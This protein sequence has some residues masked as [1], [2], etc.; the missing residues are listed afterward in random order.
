MKPFNQE[1]L[2]DIR[3]DLSGEL[4]TDMIMECASE[5]YDNL[6]ES[7]LIDRWHQIIGKI[8]LKIVEEFSGQMYDSSPCWGCDIGNTEITGYI[9]HYAMENELFYK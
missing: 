1:I 2:E 6:D 7:G 9:W 3:Y 4:A 8:S 5:D